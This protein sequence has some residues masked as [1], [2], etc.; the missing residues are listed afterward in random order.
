[1]LTSPYQ[2]SSYATGSESKTTYWI[3]TE[4]YLDDPMS[5]L[6]KGP[7]LQ[8]DQLVMSFSKMMCCKGTLWRVTLDFVNNGASIAKLIPNENSSSKIGYYKL[9]SPEK[10][11]GELNKT[12]TGCGDSVINPYFRIEKLCPCFIGLPL[13]ITS[14]AIAFI[15]SFAGFFIPELRPYIAYISMG[16]FGFAFLLIAF[17][18]FIWPFFLKNGMHRRKSLNIFSLS[19]NAKIATVYST[20]GG[21]CKHKECLCEIECYRELDQFQTIALIS[22]IVVE[23]CE[24]SE[25]RNSSD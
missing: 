19:D 10:Q 8:T 1:M 22:T 14:I 25:S 6:Y 21:C 18:I 9:W 16:L 17:A 23:L 3:K 11:I 2:T 15:G 4:K 12:G 5:A 7:V 24:Y 20:M 13:I